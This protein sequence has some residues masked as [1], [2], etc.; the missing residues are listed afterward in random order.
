MP[1][2]PH[3]HSQLE[4]S[5]LGY[6]KS[7]YWP[8]W[9]DRSHKHR[10][11]FGESIL[12]LYFEG[13]AVYLRLGSDRLDS[14][15]MRGIYFHYLRT[16]WSFLNHL[17]PSNSTWLAWIAHPLPIHRPAPYLSTQTYSCSA[18]NFHP[19]PFKT[20]PASLQNWV[21]SLRNWATGLRMIE[22]SGFLARL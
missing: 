15:C 14:S 20:G 21:E 18:R 16:V 10:R 11:G 3:L 8:A 9:S 17:M 12:L 5:S 22:T 4:W 7:T 19:E 6:F 1:I 2:R 13:K